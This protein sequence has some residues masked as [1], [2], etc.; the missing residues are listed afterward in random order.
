MCGKCDKSSS[1]IDRI[2]KRRYNERISHILVT[3]RVA[4]YKET[5]PH[6]IRR[7]VVAAI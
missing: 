5:P 6:Y 4:T 1:T 3:I 2:K 7:Q